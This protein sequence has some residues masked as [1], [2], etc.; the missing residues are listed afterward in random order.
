MSC[1]NCYYTKELEW[2]KLDGA[3][4]KVGITD[5]AQEAL[6]EITFVEL[7]AVG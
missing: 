6:G 5:D 3:A 7:P 1:E 4:A 2:I